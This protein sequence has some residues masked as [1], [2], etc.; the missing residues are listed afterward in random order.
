MSTYKYQA[1]MLNGKVVKGQIEAANETEARVKLRAQQMI[2]VSVQAKADKGGKGMAVDGWFAPK[3]NPKDLQIFTRQFST[4]IG[5]GIPVV[6]SLELLEKATK[7]VALKMALVAV[8]NDIS[9][10]RR[11]AESME[12][13]TKVFDRLYVNLVK[14]GEEG[15]VLDTILNRLAVYIEKAVKLKNKVV[16]AMYYPIGVIAISAL[17]IFAIM[18]FV[19]P[20]FE[21]LFK[22]SGM[23]LPVP[24]KIVIACSHFVQDYWWMIAG[25]VFGFISLIKQYYATKEGRRALDLVMLKMPV[26]GSMLQKSAIARFSRTLSTLLSCGVGIMD[27]LDVSARVSGNAII[28]ETLLKAKQVIAEGKSIVIPLSQDKFIPEM[29]T[30]MIGVGEQ[31]G[32]MDT[33]LAK[34]ADFYE[35]EV[36]TAVGALTSMI[37]PLMMVFLGG[38]IGMIVIAMYL[39]IFDLASSAK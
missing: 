25:G 9:S 14:A 13:H 18:K 34:I 31:T 19:I 6:Q 23:E 20:Q 38:L 16:G 4:L 36:D 26:F 2:P 12:R 11:L 15:G 30:Q 22:E 28:E 17:V 3:V 24:T 7:N 33:M 5:S 1:K 8:R 39:P 27:A 35:E 29:V 21:K 37:E 32:A 10:G